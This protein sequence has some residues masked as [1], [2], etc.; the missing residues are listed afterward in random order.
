ME[1]FGSSSSHDIYHKQCSSCTKKAAIKQRSSNLANRVLAGT[2]N[3]VSI[4]SGK[5][6]SSFSAFTFSSLPEV[7]QTF[8][9][10]GPAKLTVVS[11]PLRHSSCHSSHQCLLQLAVKYRLRSKR[12]TA[13]HSV[14]LGDGAH[15]F[16]HILETFMVISG[17]VM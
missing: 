7:Y 17:L 12:W 14:Y 13:L 1:K 10:L 15:C 8:D 4:S 9:A 3:G 6:F 16:I 2:S 5:S 11:L